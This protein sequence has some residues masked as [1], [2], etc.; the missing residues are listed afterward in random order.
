[1]RVCVFSVNPDDPFIADAELVTNSDGSVSFKLR[2]G[3]FAGQEP[4]QYGVRND[5]PA[6]GAYQKATLTGSVVTFV[7]RPEDAPMV[8]A[9]GVGKSY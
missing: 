9:C 1:M 7:T 3:N 6:I 5:N 8:Y 2:D 4:N